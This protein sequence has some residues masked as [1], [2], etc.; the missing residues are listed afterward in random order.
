MNTKKTNQL[1]GLI[2]EAA[3]SPSKWT[4]LMNAMAE[5]AEQ[6]QD[7]SNLLESDQSS[8]SGLSGIAND[9][10][11]PTASIYET[12]KSITNI[13]EDETKVPVVDVEQAN[14]LLI[15]HFARAIKIAK[16]LIDADEQHNVVLSLLD[17]M[18]IA[19]VLVDAKA[20][21]IETNALANDL[22]S[23]EDGLKV[24]SG[25]LDSGSSNNKRL[26]NA[27]EMISK[28]DSDLTRGESLS[29]T[30]EKTQNNIMLF[31]APL[32]QLSTQ[33]NA[34]VA[35]FISQRKSMPLSLPKKFAE[36]Y[37]LTKKELDVTEQ[38]VRGLSIKNISEQASVSQHTIRSQVKSILKK[39]GTSRQA[40]LVSL[41]YNGVA[42]LG[43]SI[44]ENLSDNQ[45]SILGNLKVGREDYQVLTL[46]DG[47]NMAYQEYGDLN[48]EPV[49]HC[50]SVAGCRLELALDSQKILKQKSVRLIVMDRPGYGASDPDPETSFIH[51][52]KDLIQLVDHLNIE[53]FSLSGYAMGGV[54]ALACAHEAPERVK[55]IAI[56]SSGYALLTTEDYRD[57]SPVY[58]M[59]YRIAKYMPKLYAL[60]STIQIKGILSDPDAFV[61]QLSKKVDQAD[62]EI[63]SSEAFRLEKITTL[64]ESLRQGGKA[65]GKSVIQLMHDWF[66]EPSTIKTSMDI[67]HG[68][69][70]YHVPLVVAQ[71]LNKKV[72]NSRCFIRE[73]EGHFMFYTH[74]E[75]ILEQLL[76]NNSDSS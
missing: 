50:H 14:N 45:N 48:G 60:F 26:F 57:I 32:K 33:Q 72:K 13:D 47:R 66:F 27:I 56:I 51:W 34:S 24:V 64:K 59:N 69:N 37:C 62:S 42:D 55:R 25:I 38:L 67:W 8:L 20:R 10:S 16:R 40:E 71:R 6:I 73:G 17:R 35:V 7:Q 68:T 15:R 36:Q 70:D 29:I 52:V 46:A 4:D 65:F 44:S 9:N 22:L 39:T 28:H 5:V 12:L 19:L 61:K 3:I 76:K 11:I 1:I 53:K 43:N 49:V 2:Y 58:K 74:W 75:E 31:I 54:Y 30:N 21:V 63:L 23:S 18:P 41:I